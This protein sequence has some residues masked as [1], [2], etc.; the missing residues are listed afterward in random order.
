M[1]RLEVG[2]N[3]PN[4]GGCRSRRAI[5]VACLVSFSY[6]CMGRQQLARN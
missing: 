1:R 5:E 6:S 3:G 4:S 2:E